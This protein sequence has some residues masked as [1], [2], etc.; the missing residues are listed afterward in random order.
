MH[1]V[2]FLNAKASVPFVCHR[3]NFRKY[4]KQL[5]NFVINDRTLS[6]L[7][8]HSG[9]TEQC[10]SCVAMFTSTISK[11]KTKT[12]RCFWAHVGNT[13]Q[14]MLVHCGSVAEKN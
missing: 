7:S 8:F 11:L 2:L 9:L 14:G 3:A 12:L 13:R 5:V 4:H 6:L 1:L 10:F